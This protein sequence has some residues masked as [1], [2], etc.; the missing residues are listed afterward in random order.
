M[1]NYFLFNFS[2][3]ANFITNYLLFLMF[4]FII[5]TLWL[6]VLP[7]TKTVVL[8]SMH[9]TES[10]SLYFFKQF[11]LSC[12]YINFL[13]FLLLWYQ[14]DQLFL[15]D[16]VNIV[17][18]NLILG[19]IQQ[20]ALIGFIGSVAFGVD[21]LNLYFLLLTAFIAPFCFLSAFDSINFYLVPYIVLLLILVI[22]VLLTFLTLNLFYFYFF[23]EI[24]LIPMFF[25][26]GF[27]GSSPRRT[28]AA[29]YFFF[30]T[31]FG[32]LFLVIAIIL[33]SFEV[34]D[35][36]IGDLI[37]LAQLLE[38]DEFFFMLL[39]SLLFDYGDIVLDI[40]FV[41]HFVIFDSELQLFFWWFFFIPFAIKIPMY[42]FHIWLPEA[43]VEAPTSGSMFLAAILLKLG[44][45]G[46][47]RFM[48]PL[49]P[50]ANIYYHPFFLTLG[51]ISIFYSSFTALRQIDIKRVIAYSSI[52]HMNFAIL[53][54]F[55]NDVYGYCGSILIFIGHGFISAGLFY[56]VGII[57][58]RYKTRLIY[59]YSG[60]VMLMPIYG[61][62]FFFFFFR[63][64]CFSGNN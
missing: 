34:D 21:P 62:F 53:G 10:K 7:I 44:S 28:L 35:L 55:N 9:S 41:S 29:F 42:P 2:F 16:Y 38:D 14:Y 43:H 3:S 36:Y 52:A 6:T 48:V 4:W 11:I 32:S 61:I 50:F 54:I 63:K 26:I 39:G 1:L 22:G 49:F 60:L 18:D 15:L 57:Y 31:M 64:Y 59:Y 47:L 58:D 24:I 13:I 5:A 20:N 45:Y 51:V 30:F 12:S 46:F 25:I 56:L 8:K 27:W 33:L 19:L 17:Y 37:A 23:F 40:R